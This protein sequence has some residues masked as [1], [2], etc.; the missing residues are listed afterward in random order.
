MTRRKKNK[1]PAPGVTVLEDGRYKV[2]ATAR[3]LQG[4]KKYVQETLP[5]GATLGQAV[6]R[7]EE[8]AQMLRTTHAP[9]KQERPAFGAFSELWIER[10]AHNGYATKSVKH[11]AYKL[12]WALPVLGDLQVNE[13]SLTLLEQVRDEIEASE[14]LVRRTGVEIWATIR[15]FV[16]RAWVEFDCAPS[17][18]LFEV[19]RPPRCKGGKTTDKRALRAGEVVALLECLEAN[20][21]RHNPG[22]GRQRRLEAQVILAGGLRAGEA[23]SLCWDDFNPKRGTVQVQKT[24][25]KT[26]RGREVAMP[27]VLVEDLVA[28]RQEMIRAQHRGLSS[29]LL[30]PSP[31]SGGRRAVS[32]LTGALK[33]AAR[34]AG[35][36][37]DVHSHTLRRTANRLAMEAGVERAD[38]RAQLGHSSE[39]MTDLYRGPRLDDKRAVAEATAVGWLDLVV[40][41][42]EDEGVNEG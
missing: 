27:K 19:I 2:L 25:E 5:V 42:G 23:L 12:S 39:A 4:K 31:N 6:D 32:G 9:E 8:L 20:V 24:V 35:I 34:G 36:E 16:R 13:A 37:I 1:S 38:L 21:E 11:T 22:A 7:R 10:L 14:K 17:I 18:D 15:Q 30:F 29:G 26:R 41:P 28:W 40:G 33:V 3:T